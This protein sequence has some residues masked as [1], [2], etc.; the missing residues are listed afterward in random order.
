MPA[1]NLRWHLSF[2]PLMLSRKLIHQVIFPIIQRHYFMSGKVMEWLQGHAHKLAAKRNVLSAVNDT[3]SSWKWMNRTVL[4]I[5]T[6]EKSKL[7]EDQMLC[8]YPA[9]HRISPPWEMGSPPIC[10]HTSRLNQWGP[11]SIFIFTGNRKM[12]TFLRCYN[13]PCKWTY[14][15]V[16]HFIRGDSFR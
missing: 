7:T 10:S 13:Q 11:I 16:V 1:C 8:S 3:L 6:S 14:E 2:L 12:Y 5:N 4:C 15:Y 9:Q